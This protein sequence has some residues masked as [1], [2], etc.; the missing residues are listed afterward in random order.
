MNKIKSLLILLFVALIGFGCTTASD[1]P[2]DQSAAERISSTLAK[3]KATLLARGSWVMEYF[4]DPNLS[5]GGWV[6][7]IE[8]RDDNTLTAWFE[9]STF[10]NADPLVTISDYAVEFGTGPMLKFNTHNDYLHFFSFPGDNGAGYQG[11]KGDFEFTLLSI[12]S[13][14]DEILMRGIKTGNIIRLKPLS[15]EYTPQSY[16]EAVQDDQM[17][18]GNTSFN[19][20][21][22]G[23][24]IGTIS[25]ANTIYQYDFLQYAESK[26]WTISYSYQKQ[27]CDNSGELVYNLEGEPV[28]QTVYVKDFVSSINLP[29]RILKLYEPYQFKGDVIPQLGGQTMQTFEWRLGVTSAYDNYTCTDSFFDFKLTK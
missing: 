21:A 17:S 7:V 29:G 20:T 10:I 16:I 19:I 25:R 13:G 18:V 4:P 3:F 15:G 27:V 12:S 23:I 8:F 11:W 24:S 28:Y 2:F 22:N 14:Y 9:G 1:E 6:Y 5:Y 26:V